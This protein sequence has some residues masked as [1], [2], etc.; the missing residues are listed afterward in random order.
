MTVNVVDVHHH[1]LPDVYRA[2]LDDSGV[3]ASLGMPL[4]SWDAGSAL[5]FMDLLGIRTAITSVAWP[6]VHFGNDRAAR[7]LARACNDFAAELVARHPGRFGAFTVVPLPDVGGALAEVEHGLDEL[8]LDGVILLASQSDGRYLGDPAFEELM[9]ELN[10]RKAVVFVHPATPLSSRDIPMTIPPFAAEF[11]FDTSRAILNL[12]WSG[13]AERHGEIE[14]IFAH[15]GGTAPFLA[16]R[17][18]LLEQLP[19]AQER[20]P[21]GIRHYLQ[22][23][24]YDLALSANPAALKALLELVPASNILYGSDHP[25]IPPPVARQVRLG[26]DEFEGFSA[27]DRR[28]ITEANPL[29]LFPRLDLACSDNVQSRPPKP[30]P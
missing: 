11:V 14:F 24:N 5:E 2:A 6:G 16:W 7:I 19:T 25:F 13:A 27:A 1:I 9:A 22:Q 29:R 4:P 23:F 15:A 28:A 12:I 30:G 8:Q 10:R 20:A 3:S 17:W 21:K 18:Q 26:M